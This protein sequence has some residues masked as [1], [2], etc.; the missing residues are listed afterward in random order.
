VR[1]TEEGGSGTGSAYSRSSAAEMLAPLNVSADEE[2][3]GSAGGAGRSNSEGD[4][5]LEPLL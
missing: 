4:E 1:V 2:Y 3:G 5:M